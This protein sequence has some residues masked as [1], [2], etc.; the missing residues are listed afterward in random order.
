MTKAA[1]RAELGATLRLRRTALAGRSPF[2]S[3][4]ILEVLRHPWLPFSES[5]CNQFRIGSDNPPG[6]VELRLQWSRR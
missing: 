3:R 1:T 6:I 5:K 2:V 4:K